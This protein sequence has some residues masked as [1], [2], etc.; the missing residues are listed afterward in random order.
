MS[1]VQYNLATLEQ[2]VS[3]STFL[4]LRTPT[5]RTLWTM[6]LA[7]LLVKRL[8]IMDQVLRLA[9]PLTI[10]ELPPIR[11][12]PRLIIQP[13][14]TTR[15]NVQIATPRHTIPQ[16][17]HPIRPIVLAHTIIQLIEAHPMFQRT[18][19]NQL[20]LRYL[21]VVADEAASEAEVDL[22]IG[23]Y[24]GGAEKEDVA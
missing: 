20:F 14:C 24:G 9:S 8:D 7:L 15:T 22:R 21:C 16:Q 18:I 10:L 1:F 19:L 23:V 5:S 17:P 13:H 11:H 6:R 12:T 4:V 3:K 2:W